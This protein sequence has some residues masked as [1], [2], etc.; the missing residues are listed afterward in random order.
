MAGAL[1]ALRQD[2]TNGVQLDGSYNL[3][4]AHTLRAGLLLSAVLM[5]LRF[6]HFNTLVRG[7]NR[8]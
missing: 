8:G 6:A 5:P 1:Y 2:F 3:T 7:K 4:P